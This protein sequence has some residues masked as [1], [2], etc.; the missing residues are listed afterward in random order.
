MRGQVTCSESQVQHMSAGGGP[1]VRPGI[2]AR[3]NAPAPPQGVP[4]PGT[5]TSTNRWVVLGERAISAASRESEPQMKRLRHCGPPSFAAS[6]PVSS[7]TR[8]MI[9]PSIDVLPVCVLT[10]LPHFP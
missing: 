1:A 10:S 6:L 2:A 9:S 5:S 7:S 4:V 8:S 3:P